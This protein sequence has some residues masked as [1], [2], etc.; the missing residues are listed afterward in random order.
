MGCGRVSCDGR[1]AGARGSDHTCCRMLVAG[2]QA[3]LVSP[4]ASSDASILPDAKAAGYIQRG[5]ESSGD[6]P[7]DAWYQTMLAA[8][9][10]A[11][12]HHCNS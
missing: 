11:H 5:N 6:V 8:T 12:P 9:R 4:P 3:S 7:H 2:S 10:Q 1:A